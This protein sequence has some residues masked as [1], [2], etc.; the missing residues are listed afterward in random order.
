MVKGSARTTSAT[1]AKPATAGSGERG[2]QLGAKSHENVQPDR[3]EEKRPS[4]ERA[5]D[6]ESANEGGRV[7]N[8][9][10]EY[11]YDGGSSLVSSGRGVGGA[12]SPGAARSADGAKQ[13]APPPSA[14]MDTAL[15]DMVTADLVKPSDTPS[16]QVAVGRLVRMMH[17]SEWMSI[18]GP[19]Y[20]TAPNF[21]A[22]WEELWELTSLDDIVLLAAQTERLLLA[23]GCRCSKRPQPSDL[24]K[25]T[26]TDARAELRRWKSQIV[27]SLGWSTEKGPFGMP[28]PGGRKPQPSRELTARKADQPAPAS[29]RK[30]P[31]AKKS[32]SFLGSDDE[33]DEDDAAD[34][35]K[36]WFG[37]DDA[38]ADAKMEDVDE[39]KSDPF[40]ELR[41]MSAAPSK[42]GTAGLLQIQTHIPLD[43]IALFYGDRDRSEESTQWLK[44]FIY[45]MKGSKQ[46][47]DQWIDT[48]ELRLRKGALHWFR[49]L[50][51]KT[52]KKWSLLCEA[53]MEYYCSNTLQAPTARY[54]QASRRT[55]EHVL[56]YLLRLNGYAKSAKLQISSSSGGAEHVRQ[57]LLTCGD[58]ELM[59][60]FYP[61]GLTRIGDLEKMIQQKLRGEERKKTRNPVARRRGYDR[62]VDKRRDD[63]RNQP[64][65]SLAEASDGEL[66]DALLQRREHDRDRGSARYHLRRGCVLATT[67]TGMITV[68]RSL[69]TVIATQTGTSSSRLTLLTAG[70]VTGCRIVM[71]SQTTGVVATRGILLGIA[72]TGVS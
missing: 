62:D 1:S 8:E 17:R 34:E 24:S 6:L 66:I 63:S 32:L 55:N 40:Q 39:F 33:D 64:R 14:D 5:S 68:S 71:S 52:R 27:Y 12:K 41:E 30:T 46:P 16:A 18:F 10:E 2:R 50:P 61:L 11:Q 25:V 44:M 13:V 53:F 31:R 4:A 3:L 42:A 58:D 7:R 21:V 20:S 15:A 47:Q 70:C 36:R 48:F 26:V 19:E 45:A 43:N 54:Y 28:P 38:T 65:V 60:R 49:Q 57:F 69:V 9:E 35:S 22:L 29:M 37:P 72:R 67:I 59:D 56:D 51:T 23:M